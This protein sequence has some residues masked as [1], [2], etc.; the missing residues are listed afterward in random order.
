MSYNF[1]FLAL[2]SW[3]GMLFCMEKDR[4]YYVVEPKVFSQ[5]LSEPSP[6]EQSLRLIWNN[7]QTGE[8]LKIFEDLKSYINR[9]LPYTR[10]TFY[11]LS[12]FLRWL[13]DEERRD[14]RKAQGVH[15]LL[16]KEYCS[17]IYYVK[18]RSHSIKS[19]FFISRRLGTF[20]PKLR[21]PNLLGK[22]D[23]SEEI[24]KLLEAF[25]WQW[26]A[27]ACQREEPLSLMQ[28]Y[29]DPHKKKLITLLHIEATKLQ[30]QLTLCFEALLRVISQCELE[31]LQEA[32]AIWFRAQMPIKSLVEK[33]DAETVKSILEFEKELSVEDFSSLFDWILKLEKEHK[34]TDIVR[35][36]KDI[37]TTLLVKNIKVIPTQTIL[38]WLENREI[39]SIVVKKLLY[40]Y[41]YKRFSKQNTINALEAFT[42]CYL[43][44]PSQDQLSSC[45]MGAQ[46]GT[47]KIYDPLKKLLI[48]FPCSHNDKI[49]AVC[50]LSN[51]NYIS[52]D[53]GNNIRIWDKKSL[54]ETNYINFSES[55]RCCCILPSEKEDEIYVGLHTG[56]IKCLKIAGLNNFA[57]LKSFQ[58]HTKAVILLKSLNK[59]YIIS[60]SFD[61]TLRVWDKDE[62]SCK[63]VF[64]V[65]SRVTCIEVLDENRVV[66]GFK[67]GT[68]DILDIAS[69][70]YRK[71]WKDHAKAITALACLDD[72]CL[73]SCSKD[74]N[75]KVWNLLSDKEPLL[76]SLSYESSLRT[77][78]AIKPFT[79]ITGSRDGTLTVFQCPYPK[80]LKDLVH[81]V[82]GQVSTFPWC[83][84]Q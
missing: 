30:R 29:Q 7:E 69:G 22:I 25:L 77:V 50:Q 57:C 5:R 80:D 14:N 39:E 78:C 28:T 32:L 53:L 71:Q 26:Y 46:N 21:E 19:E 62:G 18:S 43:V 17:V 23:V 38:K 49:V 40:E 36:M 84:I 20:F 41:C 11:D 44:Q 51:H 70:C 54:K 45:C 16:C 31:P 3:T 52:L 59:K 42:C 83:L 55:E 15:A 81:Y 12:E 47:L 74:G 65:A 64:K 48:S 34:D 58:G 1:Y 13:V 61:D 8:T 76:Q 4:D 2:C 67:N 10:N 82:K 63:K 75:I 68:I 33:A 72:T 9:T 6:F 24:L 79:L 27:F 35:E 73:V 56:I 66:L 37:Y 60:S